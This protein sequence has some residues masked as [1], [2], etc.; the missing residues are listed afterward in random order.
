VLG[1]L[2]A[3]EGSPEHSLANILQKTIM[4][5]LLRLYTAKL[6]FLVFVLGSLRGR[7]PLMMMPGRSPERSEFLIDALAVFHRLCAVFLA[8]SRIRL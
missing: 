2:S 6:S 5:T 3:K 8:R 4:Q 1:S 7:S